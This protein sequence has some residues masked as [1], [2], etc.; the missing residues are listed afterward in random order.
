MA[1]FVLAALTGLAAAGP[2]IAIDVATGKVLSQDN[3]SQRWYPASTTKLM[4]AYLVLSDISEGRASLDTPVVMSRL[5]AGQAP[6]KMGYPAGSVMRL[7][8]A[9][10][11]LLVKSANDVAV[12]IGETLAE[13]HEAFVARMNREAARLGMADT[14]FVNPNGLPGAGQYTTARDLAILGRAIRQEFPS[15]NSYFG[16][17]AIRAGDVQM[18]NGNGLLGRYRGADG[19]KTGYI[20]ASG[21]N[22][23]SSATRDGRTVLVVVLGA[24]GPISRE[25]DSARLLEQGFS[26]NPA[27]ISLLVEQLPTSNGPPTD[28]SAQICSDAARTAR[29]NERQVEEGRA[30]TYG[31]PYM[32]DRDRE[33][34]TL[35]VALGGAAASGD[36]AAGIT[37]IAAYGIPVPTAR[38]TLPGDAVSMADDRAASVTQQ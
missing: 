3:A 26:A 32:T 9:L 16:I 24:D 25:R 15:F 4:T 11:M 36:I 38:P 31:S 27:D 6:G 14:Q 37:Q 22:L 30:Q 5:A 35:T 21:F 18:V 7:D 17:E 2:S 29:A 13:S 12:A 23:V 20:C 8:K 33:P 1:G 34:V 19:M 10:Q 28:V